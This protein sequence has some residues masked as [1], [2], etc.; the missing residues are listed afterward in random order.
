[1]S[2]EIQTTKTLKCKNCGSPDVYKF[3]NYKG[4]QRFMCKSCHRKFK[5]DD[6]QFSLV[7][8][9]VIEEMDFFFSRN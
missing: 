2:I 5:A 3:G 7:S 8:L 4:V 1:M 9:A 6:T